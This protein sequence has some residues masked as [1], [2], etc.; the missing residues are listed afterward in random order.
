MED[1]LALLDRLKRSLGRDNAYI[2]A[3]SQQLDRDISLENIVA[4]YEYAGGDKEK[5]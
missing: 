5:R 3:P 4:M 2:I 1:V